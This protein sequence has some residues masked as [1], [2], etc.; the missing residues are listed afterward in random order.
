MTDKCGDSSRHRIARAR[1]AQHHTGATRSRAVKRPKRHR[2]QAGGPAPGCRQQKRDALLRRTQVRA[3]T[4]C[5]SRR[6]RQAGPQSVRAAQGPAWLGARRTLRAA[7]SL[8]NVLTLKSFAMR[9]KSASEHSWPSLKAPEAA[10][11]ARHSGQTHSP[12]GTASSGGVRQKRWHPRSQWSHRMIWSS[13]CPPPHSSQ[14]SSKMLSGTRILSAPFAAALACA[15]AGRPQGAAGA[16]GPAETPRAGRLRRAPA[17]HPRSWRACVAAPRPPRRARRPSARP[18]SPRPPPRRQPPRASRRSAPGPR[19]GAARRARAAQ[20]A[21]RSRRAAR[22]S[23]PRTPA[24]AS[25]RPGA[26][27]W[28]RRCGP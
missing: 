9:S 13:W 12:S 8:P 23:A 22:R 15:R 10:S 17:R 4:R 3:A 7:L 19:R 27:C 26:A 2:S 18:V 1:P 16:P 14:S 5:S 25:G 11:A 20:P 24:G 21:R 28:P 6:G